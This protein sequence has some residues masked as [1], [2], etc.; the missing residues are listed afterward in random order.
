MLS[1]ASK[2]S[3]L[4]TEF[5]GIF[6]IAMQLWIYNSF[7]R[8]ELAEAV[9]RDFSVEKETA[10]GLQ[11]YLKRGSRHRYFPVNFA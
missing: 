1:N 7:A 11:L 3:G 5:Q 9:A 2:I 4:L 6:R 10:K 8:P